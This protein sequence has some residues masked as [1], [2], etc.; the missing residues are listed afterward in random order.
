MRGIWP[1]V[2]YTCLMRKVV[3]ASGS[4]RRKKLL[5]QIGLEFEVCVSN[6]DE[7]ENATLPPHDLVKKLSREKA[8]IVSKKYKD[9]IIIS[10]DTLVSF[11]NKILGKPLTDT[12]ATQMLSL[13]SG[14]PHIIITGFTIL[15]T[16]TGK[17]ISQSVET[18]VYMK[19]LTNEEIK[20]YVKTGE[21]H[22]KAGGYGIQEKG[23]VL[24]AKIEGDFSNVVGLPLSALVAELK[25]FKIK[26][27]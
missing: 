15:D 9:A 26:I 5:E 17:T 22:D 13:L 3:L 4:P 12:G 24:V 14:N 10:A 11:K 16:K 23:A 25:K 20:D 2:W 7:K 8:K 18:K 6:F 1:L 21:P 19:K 27:I